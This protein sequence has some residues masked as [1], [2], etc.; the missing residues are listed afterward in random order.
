MCVGIIPNWLAIEGWG[1]ERHRCWRSKPVTP[2]L[3]PEV[4]HDPN[5]TARF[6]TDKSRGE[7]GAEAGIRTVSNTRDRQSTGFLTLFS[8]MH[9]GG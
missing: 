6:G 8:P 5:V 1:Y 2:L 3:P 9:F 4:S 7:T